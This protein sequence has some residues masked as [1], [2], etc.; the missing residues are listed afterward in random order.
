MISLEYLDFDL[1][2]EK[3]QDGYRAH[4]LNWQGAQA[5]A[6]LDL[7]LT[8][9]EMNGYLE[10]LGHRRL[11]GAGDAR[12]ASKAL[13]GK[14][15]DALFHDDVRV[16]WK[17]ALTF[18]DAQGKGVRLHLRMSDAPELAD[19]PWELLYDAGANSF[20]N[21]SNMTPLVRF[22]ELPNPPRSLQLEPPLRILGVLSLPD[23]YLELGVE[24][25]WDKLQDALK[26]LSDAGLVELHR[27]KDA[28]TGNLQAQLRRSEF[29][30]LHFIGHGELD[31]RTNEGALVFENERGRGRLV[32]GEM[33]GTLL[34]DAR[35]L[36]LVVLNAC[37][38][39]R[40]DRSD[41]FGGVAQRLV[42]QTIPAVIAMQFE[43]TDRAAREFG[44]EFYKALADN[45]PIEAALGEARKAIYGLPNETEWATP[46]LYSR[47]PDGRLFDIDKS[48]TRS[49]AETPSTPGRNALP[50]DELPRAGR[51]QSA[52]PPVA[53]LEF[54]PS[55]RWNFQIRDESATRM[56]IE[57]SA[58]GSFEMT[59][60]VGMLR[61]PINGTWLFNPLT[62]NLALQG[63]INTFQPFTLSLTITSQRG[64]AFLA[65]DENG[66]VYLLTR[67]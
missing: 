52:A 34:R 28:T 67:A 25:E 55:G 41:P 47:S 22:L 44:Q 66:I 7:K 5:S 3:G 63:I 36:R 23:D 37:E 16:L 60:H 49:G 56:T 39:A 29:H 21:L 40:T 8:D 20:L 43:I 10:Q 38:G 46:V 53:A 57:L 59:Q 19:L 13:G 27:L 61:V 14:L 17:T 6:P 26:K 33:L 15:F 50:N 24:R 64:S 2:I 18:A 48:K 51:T 30:I 31:S 58:N 1:S 45:F 9:D 4:V 62:Q 11:R 35:S 12:T 54:N 42:Q 65:A 32:S